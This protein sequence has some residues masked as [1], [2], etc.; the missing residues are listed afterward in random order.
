[1]N[2]RLAFSLVSLLAL[3]L[4]SCALSPQVVTIHPQPPELPALPFSIPVFLQV[5]DQRPGPVIGSRGGVY[6]SS[7]I[8]TGPSLV[9]DTRLSLAETF[10]D[11][12]F[13]IHETASAEALQF[14]LSI[15][16]I[17]YE[18]DRSM[19]GK[20]L[21]TAQFSVEIL[22]GSRHYRGKYQAQTETG[23]LASP[24]E[25]KNS[26]LINQVYNLTLEKVFQDKKLVTFLF[27]NQ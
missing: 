13:Q 15:D 1:M 12:G 25:G 2:M 6:A 27:G 24:S 23:Y 26:Q 3:F 16:H 4:Q 10:S 11:S 5:N 18:S 17:V 9:E 21:L 20:A 14:T 8:E 22:K 7:T 19:A